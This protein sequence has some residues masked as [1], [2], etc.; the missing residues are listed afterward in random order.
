MRIPCKL[1]PGKRIGEVGVLK[2]PEGGEINVWVNFFFF[3]YGCDTWGQ[4]KYVLSRFCSRETI[5]YILK[6]KKLRYAFL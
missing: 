3:F 5:Y 2:G 1:L 6:Y 4:E